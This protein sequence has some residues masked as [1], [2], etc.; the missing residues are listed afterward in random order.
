MLMV[1][2]APALGGF[3]LGHFG[4]YAAMYAF[5]VLVV[6]AAVL[7]SFAK[8]VRSVPH[9]REWATLNPDNAMEPAGT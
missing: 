3:L 5:V 9:S 7:A 8:G 1:P 2:I 4:H 6:V